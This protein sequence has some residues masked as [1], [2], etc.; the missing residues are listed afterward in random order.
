MSPFCHITE[1]KPPD[2]ATFLSGTD[3]SRIC[4]PFYCPGAYSL[5]AIRRQAAASSRRLLQEIM[6]Q[7]EAKLFTLLRYC[8]L[9]SEMGLSHS[10]RPAARLASNRAFIA[11]GRSTVLLSERISKVVEAVRT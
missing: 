3:H 5:L 10:T 8:H 9:L 7:T 6:V 4:S 2:R 1:E 11:R